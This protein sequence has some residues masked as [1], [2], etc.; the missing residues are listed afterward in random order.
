M[1]QYETGEPEEDY[2]IS[3]EGKKSICVSMA[4]LL[5]SVVLS[6]WLHNTRWY[7][8]MSGQ[9]L[10]CINDRW[11]GTDRQTCVRRQAEWVAMILL[12]G[13]CRRVIQRALGVIQ[14]EWQG[15]EP[16]GI[17]EKLTQE[18]DYYLDSTCS[19]INKRKY[20]FFVRD[21]VAILV[22]ITRITHEWKH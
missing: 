22:C 15:R 14:N 2:S 1:W 12:P 19:S 11:G 16:H 4:L 13:A 10:A 9:V 5:A 8:Q 21:I 18:D 3:H 20:Q 6:T 17:S 7:W